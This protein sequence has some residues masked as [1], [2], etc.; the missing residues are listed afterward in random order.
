VIEAIEVGQTNR[1]KLVHAQVDMPEHGERD[2]PRFVIGALRQMRNASAMSW[3]RHIDCLFNSSMI[4]DVLSTLQRAFK[5][6]GYQFFGTV[7]RRA[8]RYLDLILRK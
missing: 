1:L 6:G 3:S 4:A 5:V 7:S 2:T 8:C